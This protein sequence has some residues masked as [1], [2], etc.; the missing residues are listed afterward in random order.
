MK[1]VDINTVGGRIRVSRQNLKLNL[2]GMA[3][4]VGISS[5]YVSIIERNVKK[6]S[7]RLLMKI[8]DV[9]GTS[10]NWLKNGERG[11]DTR[12]KTFSSQSPNSVGI[13][14]IANFNEVQLLLT[15]IMQQEPSITKEIVAA[16]LAVGVDDVEKILSG[17]IEDNPQWES[18]LSSLIQR[19]DIPAV[20]EKIR[21]IDDV[22]RR[23]EKKLADAKLFQSFRD[24]LSN[25]CK[26]TFK[27]A[28]Q[29]VEVQ[30][31]YRCTLYVLQC[32]DK[33]E[34]W[35]ILYYPSTLDDD[36]D[37]IEF[38]NQ[39]TAFWKGAHES[40]YIEEHNCVA[41]AFTDKDSYYRLFEHYSKFI[42]KY[43]IEAEANSVIGTTAPRSTVHEIYDRVP[44]GIQFILV[45][46]KTAEI[47]DMQELSYPED[48]YLEDISD[49]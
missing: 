22:L 24:Y 14:E 31:E 5:N 44:D 32:V 8:A 45:D 1:H 46:G 37:L 42:D 23:E 48:I 26:A 49:F 19:M 34:R 12:S 28:G 36:D 41:V 9:T 35:S 30:D 29:P 10:F 47:K 4:R 38:G 11:S 27:F 20:R 39:V 3:E 16:V 43:E 7:D 33:S 15:I 25:E 17:E 2:E 40:C 13:H 21:G 18:G 6:P